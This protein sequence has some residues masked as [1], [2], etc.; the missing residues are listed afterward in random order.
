MSNNPN[1]IVDVVRYFVADS[2]GYRQLKQVT[3][4]NVQS[5]KSMQVAA[6]P[7][8]TVGTTRSQGGTTLSVST[9][10]A[11]GVPDEV[12]WDGLQADDERFRFEVQYEGGKRFQYIECRVASINDSHGTGDGNVRR[13]ISLMTHLD[14]NILNP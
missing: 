9:A 14:P 1:P 2:A 10:H 6:G 4:V 3:G 11:K 8:G 12:D 7:S 13:E 5:G